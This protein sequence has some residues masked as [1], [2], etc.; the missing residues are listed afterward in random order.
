MTLAVIALAYLAGSFPSGVVLSRLLTGR[1]VRDV[2]SGNIGA[3]NAARAG[4]FRLG[5]AVALLDALKGL[6]MIV[7]GRWAG[8]GPAALALVWLAAVLGHDFSLFLRFRGGKGVATT[9]GAALALALLPTIAAVVV[10][11]GALLRSGYPSLAS[12]LALAVLPIVFWLDGRP[13]VLGFMAALLF[14]LSAAKH[15]GNI[16]RLLAGTEPTF[17]R[18]DLDRG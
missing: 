9:L 4:G 1:D 11:V 18:R 7:L 14:A 13:P 12:L 16:A 6:L 2:G 3:A 5:A 10:Y 15:A 17:R 8:L